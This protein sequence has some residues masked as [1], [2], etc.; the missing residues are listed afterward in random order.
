MRNLMITILVSSF[1]A[2]TLVGCGGDKAA[3]A[4]ES[5]KTEAKKAEPAKAEAKKAEPAKAEAKKAEPAKAAA[6]AAPAPAD[7]KAS[8]ADCK[9]ACDNMTKI[10]MASLPP[11]TPAEVKAEA[12]KGLATCPAECQKESTA[13][14]AKCIGAAK[15]PEDMEK[16]AG[17]E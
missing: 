6:P 16:C 1:V 13:A 3:P 17:G 2:A 15:S 4:A 7:G 12:Q 11:E 14:E 10:L 8:A 5:A 9:A